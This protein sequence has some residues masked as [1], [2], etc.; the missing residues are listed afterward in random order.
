MTVAA[1]T[2]GVLTHVDGGVATVTLS[3]PLRKNALTVQMW[4][5]LATAVDE[6]DG[7]SRRAGHGDPR[8]STPGASS[9][10]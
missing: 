3:N 5:D 2:A 4:A 9:S 7:Q 6:L 10:A 1:G 8:R